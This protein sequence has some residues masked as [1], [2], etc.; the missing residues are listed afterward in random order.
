M[1]RGIHHDTQLITSSGNLNIK[2]DN[3]NGSDAESHMSLPSTGNVLT[4]F[5]TSA[6][7]NCSI[8]AGCVFMG[9][10]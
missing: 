3:A 9:R 10:C 7:V 1:H 8:H 2:T 5:H 4:K 6:K